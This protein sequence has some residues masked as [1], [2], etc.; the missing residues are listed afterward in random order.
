[1]G[2][3]EPLA[4]SKRV[5][6]VL[7]S[8]TLAIAAIA[9]GRGPR[10]R[11]VVRDQGTD[12]RLV[13]RRRLAGRRLVVEQARAEGRLVVEQ[14]GAEGRL[15]VEQGRS[16]GRLELSLPRERTPLAALPRT[17]DAHSPIRRRRWYLSWG[18]AVTLCCRL[19]GDT[20]VGA[21]CPLPW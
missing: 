17:G 16:E 15:V 8:A 1:M 19:S 12:R 4:P 7:C 14:A 5:R 2:K 9:P 20:A 18:T 6:I 3:I 11:L 13:V 21:V 10:R